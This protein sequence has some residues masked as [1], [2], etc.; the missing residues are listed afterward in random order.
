M[1]MGLTKIRE[2]VCS[3]RCSFFEK[4]KTKI[5]QAQKSWKEV[6]QNTLSYY[7]LLV[8]SVVKQVWLLLYSRRTSSSVSV[9]SSFY[10]HN[11]WIWH[12][13]NSGVML[14]SWT[15]NFLNIYNLTSVTL[16][17]M[18]P[19]HCSSLRKNLNWTPPL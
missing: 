8:G 1:N 11:I 5:S 17:L 3:F 13:E 18:G 7:L 16:W 15:H 4:K 9:T 14:T 12:W 10:S 2:G 19:L 6:I